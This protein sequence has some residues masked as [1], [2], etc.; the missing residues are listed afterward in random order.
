MEKY[1]KANFDTLIWFFL[2]SF[3]FSP[4]IKVVLHCLVFCNFFIRHTRSFRY[5]L[6]LSVTAE[7]AHIHILKKVDY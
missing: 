2:L 3:S 7:K 1:G 5:Q 6:T 4:I